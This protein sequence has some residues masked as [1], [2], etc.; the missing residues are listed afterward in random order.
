LRKTPAPIEVYND[1]DGE[2]VNLFRVA[3]EH[4]DDLARR[5]KWTPFA[6]EE[7]DAAYL[8]TDDPIEQARRTLVRS[9]MSF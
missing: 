2:I 3:R 5:I 6:R 8:P 9:Y 1:L 4:T 7:F